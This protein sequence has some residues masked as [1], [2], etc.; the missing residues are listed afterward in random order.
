MENINRK[1]VIKKAVEVFAT[2]NEGAKTSQAE[3]D[4]FVTAWEEAQ[5]Q[6]VEGLQGEKQEDGTHR[7]TGLKYNPYGFGVDKKHVITKSR[8]D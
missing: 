6:L 2:Q 3:M 8:I 4:R 1:A 7:N 5:F